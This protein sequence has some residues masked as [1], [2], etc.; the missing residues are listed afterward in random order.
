MPD[1]NPKL[2][3]NILTEALLEIRFDSPKQLPLIVGNMN[4]LLKDYSVFEDL[5]VPEFPNEPPALSKLVRFRFHTEDRKKLYS[6]GTGVLSVNSLDYPG[7]DNFVKEIINVLEVYQKV[8]DIKNITRIGLRYINK[9][10][11]EGK[12]LS[13]LLTINNTMPTP[14][15]DIE[16]G[17]AIQSNGQIDGDVL[18][19][20]LVSQDQFSTNNL[21]LDFDYYTERQL[22]FDIPQLTTWIKKAHAY[23]YKSFK[24]SLTEDYFNSI[25]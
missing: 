22:E 11:T 10:P 2:K 8:S 12:D 25:S 5:H 4:Y 13:E 18:L 3:V 15:K 16:K 17:F 19:T 14:I 21:L 9:I 20:K 7:F 6:L 1:S 23:I 24:E